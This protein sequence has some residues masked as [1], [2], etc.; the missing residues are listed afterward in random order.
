MLNEGTVLS[1]S[2]RPG[3]LGGT[4]PGGGNKTCGKSRSRVRLSEGLRRISLDSCPLARKTI[5]RPHFTESCNSQNSSIN[6][7]KETSPP[8]GPGDKC[9]KHW[10]L[11]YRKHLSGPWENLIYFAFLSLPNH[12]EVFLPGPVTE[13]AAAAAFPSATCAALPYWGHGWCHCWQGCHWQLCLH[14]GW[15][16]PAQEPEGEAKG[17]GSAKQVQKKYIA[18]SRLH[19]VNLGTVFEGCLH[20]RAPVSHPGS[21]L[22]TAAPQ[23]LNLRS[24]HEPYVRNPYT[25]RGVYLPS[26]LWVESG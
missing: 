19:M 14:S 26:G 5:K 16:A 9:F 15:S 20:L 24:V 11:L 22:D 17:L 25:T 21:P 13:A 1:C 10:T 8:S 18:H 6:Q 4:S 3:G 7:E 23:Q 2:C 12:P